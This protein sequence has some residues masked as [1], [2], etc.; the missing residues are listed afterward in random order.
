MPTLQDV[1]DKI[2]DVA[3]ALARQAAVLATLTDAPTASGPDVALLVDLHALR[4]D[5]LACAATARSRRERAAFEAMAAGLERLLV[6]RGGTVVAPGVG[7]EFR[8]TQMEAAEVVAAESPDQDRTV[9]TLLE[10][11]L[12]V[13]GRSVRPARVAVFRTP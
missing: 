10:S 5:A 12:E 4:V 6:G 1:S 9:A 2:D 13:S 7:D 8:G 11:G 3:R